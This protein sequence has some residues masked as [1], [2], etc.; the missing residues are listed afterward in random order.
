VTFYVLFFIH[1]ESR[2]VHL[3]GVTPN[4]DGRWMARVAR[5]MSMVFAEEPDESRPT[6]SIRDRDSKF[7]AQFCP[8]LETDGIEFRPTP[9]QSPNLNP[10]AEAWVQKTKHEVLNHFIVFGENHLRRIL[11][12]WLEYYHFRRPHQGLGNV[13]ITGESPPDVSLDDFRRDKIVCHETLGGLLKH[14][15]RRAA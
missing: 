14:Y 13:P 9:R 10:F 2:R 6:H 4:P 5:N 11:A 3:A 1:L 15:E 12:A 7:T 8:I